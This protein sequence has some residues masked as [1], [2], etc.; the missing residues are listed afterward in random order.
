MFSVSGDAT[1]LLL[2]SSS[3]SGQIDM[4]RFGFSCKLWIF[5]SVSGIRVAR[6]MVT[7]RRG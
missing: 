7:E 3:L 6:E 1:T 2:E 5:E 4:I